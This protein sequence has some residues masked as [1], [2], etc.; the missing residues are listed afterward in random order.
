MCRTV[1]PED[2]HQVVLNYITAKK[3]IIGK[4]ENDKVFYYTAAECLSVTV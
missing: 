3:L 2:Q 1:G 4:S